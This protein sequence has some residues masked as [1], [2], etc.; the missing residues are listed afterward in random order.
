MRRPNRLITLL[1]L[2]AVMVAAVGCSSDPESDGGSTGGAETTTAATQ[3]ES[4]TSTSAGEPVDQ[5]LGTGVNG[6]KIDGEGN[7]WTASIA[8][9]QLIKID[10]ATGQILQ[11]IDAPEGSGPDDLVIDDD[12]TI[13][14]TG[15]LT[16][17]VGRADPGSGEAE[18][19]GPVGSAANPIA[20]RDDGML[21]VGRAVTASGL[22]A[23][24]PNS[25][26][27]EELADPGNVNSFS[28][29]PDGVLYGPLASPEGGAALAIDAD[30]GEVIEKVADIPG[31]P[32]ALRWSDGDLFVLTSNNGAQIYKVDLASRELSLYSDLGVG[33]CDNLAVADSGSIYV[34]QFDQ[35]RILEVGSDG[36]VVRVIEIGG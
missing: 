20:I 12:G 19:I 6:I 3:P 7:L 30:N 5:T 14:W 10:F 15:Y 34:T 36:T 8:A 4:T 21:V 1:A 18:V 2:A 11:R 17:T 32:T 35:P 24:D 28:I 33:F 29:A 16:G 26:E 9:N 13:Y 31:I 23:M 27:V 25:G 22:Y